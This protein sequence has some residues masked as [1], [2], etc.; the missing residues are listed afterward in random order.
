MRNYVRKPKK[1]T[2]ANFGSKIQMFSFYQP[3]CGM[4]IGKVELGF[5][6]LG[7]LGPVLFLG[8]ENLKTWNILPAACSMVF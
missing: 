7:H 3:R 5:L 4:V 8:M 6:G 1:I 2:C